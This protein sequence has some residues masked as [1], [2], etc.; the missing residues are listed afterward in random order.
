MLNQFIKG[1]ITCLLWTST[2]DKGNP[3]DRDHCEEDIS[4][5]AMKMIVDDC[6]K[7]YGEN[8][9]NLIFYTN[10]VTSGDGEP[11]ATAGHDFWCTRSG[12]GCGFWD[13]DGVDQDIGIFLTDAACKYKNLSP[14]VGD[15]DL[16]YLE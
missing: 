7:F 15:D 9:V 6:V 12:Q 8:K 4:K 3:L 5:E 2:D 16:I 14:I 11:W 13:R 10:E 1:Y